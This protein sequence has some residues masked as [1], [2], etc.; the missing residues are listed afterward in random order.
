M[1]LH[2]SEI[3]KGDVFVE[4]AQRGS[5]C[6]RAVSEPKQTDGK[7]WEWDAENVHT[8]ALQHYLWSGFSYGPQ[9]YWEPAYVQLPKVRNFLA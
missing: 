9:L 3:H 7:T 5:V 6:M 2:P 1:S 4:G 8:G